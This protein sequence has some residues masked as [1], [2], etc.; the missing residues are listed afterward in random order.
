MVHVLFAEA[1]Q[2]DVD[3]YT[4]HY[5]TLVVMVGLGKV[6]TKSPKPPILMSSMA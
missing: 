3:L 6:K 1:H 2:Q 5:D 4:V